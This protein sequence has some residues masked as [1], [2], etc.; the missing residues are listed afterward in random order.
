M[1][2]TEPSLL[3]GLGYVITFLRALLGRVHQ[4]GRIERA[5]VLL[6]HRCL[7]QILRDIERMIGR[8]KAGTLVVRGV[9]AVPVPTMAGLTMSGS[10]MSGSTMSGPTSPGQVVVEAEPCRR[11]TSPVIWPRGS[12][13]LVRLAGHEA[14]GMGSQLRHL[15]RH[16]DM[17]ALLLAAPQAARLLRPMCRMLGVE[18]SLLDPRL[19]LPV[20]VPA[21]MR[22]VKPRV[23][24]KR[25]PIDWGR[26]PLPRGVLTAARRAGFK[27]VR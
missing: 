23:R 4:A 22:V 10:T 17:V 9:R 12:M 8:M 21:V 5:P 13:W 7:G 3:F 25:V 24:A 18:T 1:E 6:V 15:L 2:I 20:F 26:I 19:P 14:A 11:A 27:P 16:P